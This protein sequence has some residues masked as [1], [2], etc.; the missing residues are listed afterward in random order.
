M[1]SSAAGFPLAVTNG[2][3]GADPARRDGPSPR[4]GQHKGEGF[5]K[6]PPAE[7]LI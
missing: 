1:E 4:C 6:R 5:A 3:G 2:K 7:V